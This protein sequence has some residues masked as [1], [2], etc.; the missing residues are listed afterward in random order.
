MSFSNTPHSHTSSNSVQHKKGAGPWSHPGVACLAG[1]EVTRLSAEDADAPGSPNSHVVYRLLSP[2]PEA[3]SEER[4]FEL[5][6]TSGSV[7]L[8]TAPL[9]AGQNI[10]LQVLATDLAGAEGGKCPDSDLGL[11]PTL[12][13]LESHQHEARSCLR[14]QQH[15]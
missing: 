8:G 6:P 5:D 4:L 1:T 15:V 14:P 7:T 9:Q 10:L 11:L 2:E 12:F 3:G 13:L